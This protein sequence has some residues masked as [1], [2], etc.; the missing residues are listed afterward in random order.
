MYETLRTSPAV[1]VRFDSLKGVSTR[2]GPGRYER[3]L[4]S[5]CWRVTVAVLV[6]P[7]GSFATSW[8]GG[9]LRMP[10]PPAASSGSVRVV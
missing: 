8:K 10:K 3:A 9:N 1:A 5:R 4:L 6:D 2:L 7:S